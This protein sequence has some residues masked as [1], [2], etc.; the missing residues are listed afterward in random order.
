[1]TVLSQIALDVDDC[2]VNAEILAML[3]QHLIRSLAADALKPFCWPTAACKTGKLR[4]NCGQER[5]E[6]AAPFAAAPTEP[7]TLY[8]HAYVSPAC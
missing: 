5:E 4:L 7:L 1:M 6:G 3:L 8:V 2:C